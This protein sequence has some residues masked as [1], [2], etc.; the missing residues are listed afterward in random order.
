VAQVVPSPYSLRVDRM[1]QRLIAD[2]YLGQLLAIEVRVGGAFLDAE[3]PLHWRQ[4]AD[5]SGLNVMSLGIWYEAVLRWVGEATHLSAMGQTF[6]RMRRTPDGVQRAVRVPEHLDVI[7]EMACGAQA[8]FQISS[9]TGLAGAPEAYLFGSQGTLRFA[10]DTLYGGQRGDAAL[11]EIPIPAD[12]EGHWR[13]EE[14]FVNAIRGKENITHTDFETG[15]KYMEF[16]EAVA[17][18][19]AEGRAVSLPLL[20]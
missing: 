19:M 20:P 4:N 12:L 1:I 15:L 11:D 7:A 17:R 13:V 8:H 6:V 9:V 10:Q 16:T 3:S 5:L 2:G 14:E 18:S